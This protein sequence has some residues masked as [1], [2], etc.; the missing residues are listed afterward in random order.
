MAHKHVELFKTAWIKEHIDSLTG[1][2]FALLM[3]LGDGLLAAAHACLGT[4]V[5]ELL[6]FFEL[7]THFYLI[8]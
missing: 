6:D 8:C 3:L 2:V 5:D 1:C 4:H 7:F